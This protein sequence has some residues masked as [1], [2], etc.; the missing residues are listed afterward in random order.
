MNRLDVATLPGGRQVNHDW[1]V[2]GL[3]SRVDYGNGMS[4]VYNYDNADRV[5]SILNTHSASESEEYVYSY[6][7]NSNR[8]TE[9]RKHNGATSRSI[10]YQF[11]S[12]NRLT[13]ANYG[14]G[15]SLSYSYDKVGNRPSE[16]GSEVG[17]A[18]VNRTYA[19]DA[20]N[21]LSTV[22]DAVTANQSSTLTYDLNGNLTKE[23]LSNGQEKRYE[24]DARNEMVRAASFNAGSETT[25]GSYDYDFE[26]RRLSK[27]VGSATTQYVYSGI[28]VVNEYDGNNLSASYD[29]GA[30]LLRSEFV[31]EGERLYFHDALGSTTSLA[32]STGTT[33][34]RYEYDA[35]GK[36]I[37]AVQPSVNK[38][39]YTGYRRDEETGLDYAQARYYDSS[40]GRFTSFDPVTENEERMSQPQG[41]NFYGY[42]MGNPLKFTD[43]T[44]KEWGRKYEGKD[45]N[46]NEVY[47]N[48]W[49]KGPV[50]QGKGWT[51]IQLPYIY[52]SDDKNYYELLPNGR[53][54]PLPKGDPG[55]LPVSTEKGR[56]KP[57]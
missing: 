23:A 39:N 42:V 13:Q 56:A 41:M 55:A 28:N 54:R 10:S 31:G 47:Q 4:R 37:S 38:V 26:G 17:G 25:L 15:A 14:S 30:D 51:A 9:T 53:W 22:T 29:Y 20:L 5:T 34:A 48:H 52:T 44:G 27:T 50:P 1:T 32:T 19:Y 46:G 16:Q 8:E 49:F 45:A 6:D 43:P 21:R 18:P 36:L 7:A 12:L 3:L 40:R 33:V 11:D 35:W 2:D 24:Y 57:Q